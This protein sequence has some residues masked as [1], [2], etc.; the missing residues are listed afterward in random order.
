MIAPGNLQALIMSFV[1]A[2]ILCVAAFDP[3][4]IS[5]P[6]QAAVEAVALA[7]INLGVFLWGY[8]KHAQSIAK[9]WSKA[10]G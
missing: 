7:G 8:M 5:N 1:D 6:Q 10:N 3:S 9:L 4:L 2:V